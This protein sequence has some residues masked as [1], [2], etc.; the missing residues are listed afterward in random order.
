MSDIEFDCP[1]CLNRLVVDE[2]GAGR[3]VDCPE[4]RKPV[5][6]PKPLHAEAASATDPVPLPPTPSLSHSHNL[7]PCPDCGKTVSIN[8]EVCLSCGHRFK[9]V[10]TPGGILAAVV[11]GL[12]LCAIIV[13]AMGGC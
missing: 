1:E 10:Q 3:V 8:A 4:C 13:V 12:L 6:I 7:Q 2:S 9:H 11:L 5:R